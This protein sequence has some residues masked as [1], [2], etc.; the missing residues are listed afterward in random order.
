[1]KI[2][3]EYAILIFKNVF[4]SKRYGARRLMSEFPGNRW[5]LGSI[6]S[7]LKRIRMTG[8]IVRPPGSGR[9]RSSRA[10]EDILLSHE[11]KPKRHRSARG[12]SHETAIL[13]SSVHRIIHRDLQLKCFKQRRTQLLSE[14]NCISIS[15]AAKQPYRLQ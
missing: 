2:S 12:I 9:P 3:Q 15:L 5:T 13:C 4:L 7:L 10:V 6:D 14:A 1:M 8:T 11:Y